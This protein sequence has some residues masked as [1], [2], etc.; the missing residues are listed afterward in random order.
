MGTAERAV[1]E[2]VE[3]TVEPVLEL[4]RELRVG[5]RLC[6]HQRAGPAH[7]ELDVDDASTVRAVTFSD[8]HAEGAAWGRLRTRVLLHR[9]VEHRSH[10]RGWEGPVSGPSRPVR[11][12]LRRYRS[13]QRAIGFAVG[14]QHGVRP[15]PPTGTARLH[16]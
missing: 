13:V 16:R 6:P 10:L 7:L 9:D 1:V 15:D 14:A 5:E 2:L 8:E 3:V 4:P 12:H 11:L